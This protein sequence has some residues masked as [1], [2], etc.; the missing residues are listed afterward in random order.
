M[1]IPKRN[2][3]YR[4]GAELQ[5]IIGNFLRSEVETWIAGCM[6]TVPEIRVSDDLRHAGIYI[7]ILI[8]QDGQ[9]DSP[10]SEN[11]VQRAVVRSLPRMRKAVAEKIRIKKM[12]EFRFFWD[13]TLSRSDRIEQLLNTIHN[14][15][16]SYDEET[17]GTS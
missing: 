8:N 12:P 2:R 14:S 5:K 6:I 9:D 10:V 17:G 4:I 13:D 11:D 3:A 15:Q 16:S 7:S 1:K